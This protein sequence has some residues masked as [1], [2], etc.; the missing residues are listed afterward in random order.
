MSFMVGVI[1]SP[2]GSQNADPAPRSRPRRAPS[3]PRRRGPGRPR[4]PGQHGHGQ[5]Q[6]AA[7]L[8]GR[9]SLTGCPGVIL[10]PR[11]PHVPS[12]TAVTG[13]Q[14][15]PCER[16][17]LTGRDAGRSSASATSFAW[18]GGR[19]CWTPGAPTLPMRP[20]WCRSARR[21]L[22]GRC[23]D[24]FTQPV[25]VAPIAGGDPASLRAAMSSATLVA[26][27]RGCSSAGPARRTSLPIRAP[28][29]RAELDLDAGGTELAQ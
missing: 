16:S 6:A 15:G 12:G 29:G 19:P 23:V 5:L 4:C 1:S 24:I 9:R 2:P 17:F 13:S 27:L 22:G 14:A 11:R 7:R 18:R 10:S 21:A 3:G 26:S 28:L 25:R 8:G 20:A